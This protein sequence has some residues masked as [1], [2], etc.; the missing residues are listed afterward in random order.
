MAV[1]LELLNRRFAC[2]ARECTLGDLL[3]HR[4]GF[5]I[6]VREPGRVGVGVGIEVI[7]ADVFHHVIALGIGQRVISFA[8][9]PFA[10]EVG[11]VATG[12][13]HRGQRPFGS[14]QTAALTLKGHGGHAAAVGDAPGLH[15]GPA[16]RATGL[17]VKR[18]EGGALGGQLIN[19]RGRH[20]SPDTATV[21]AQVTVAGV[22]GDD[23]QDVG[24]FCL[25]RVGQTVE[26]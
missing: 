14:R 5:R 20:A 19:A 17:G 6:H 18:I 12:F 8:Q 13:Q 9:M 7:K 23:E 16:R 21:G 10:G 24:F 2:L 26:R 1:D 3:E 25:C 4:P 15:G 22:V 11:V